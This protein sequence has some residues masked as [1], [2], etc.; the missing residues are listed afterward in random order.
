M[1]GKHV[2]SAISHSREKLCTLSA[3]LLC[4]GCPPQHPRAG[5][6]G[7]DCLILTKLKRNL[8]FNLKFLKHPTRNH[9]GLFWCWRLQRSQSH[10][11]LCLT[12]LTLVRLCEGRVLL[13]VW[14][15]FY[16]VKASFKISSKE[17]ERVPLAEPKGR[18]EH[19]QQPGIPAPTI[20]VTHLP[21][22]W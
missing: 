7:S 21:D 19:I 13:L 11:I 14:I 8:L 20:S 10:I 3:T 5:C 4:P 12:P 18:C 16:A 1:F 9:W 6:P 17:M 15:F 22:N 2:L